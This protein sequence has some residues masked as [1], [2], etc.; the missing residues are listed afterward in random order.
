MPVEAAA[1]GAMPLTFE[2]S[3]AVRRE[4]R[5]RLRRL[6]QFIERRQPEIDA[7]LDGYHVPRVRRQE[8]GR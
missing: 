5:K 8:S 2:I 1:D 3:M 4:D 7:I 6:D